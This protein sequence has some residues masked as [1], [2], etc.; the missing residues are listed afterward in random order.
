MNEIAIT[1]SLAFIL[2]LAIISAARRFRHDT[3][4]S[5][6]CLEFGLEPLE[7]RI[8]PAALA[9]KLSSGVLFI[10]AL[11]P[12]TQWNRP[13]SLH[14]Q[15]PILGARDEEMNAAPKRKSRPVYLTPDALSSRHFIMISLAD[16]LFSSALS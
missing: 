7:H 16:F 2:G 12:S 3:V 13:G 4:E 11:H 6:P 8:A 10:T 9:A 5:A 15:H 14:S 1:L